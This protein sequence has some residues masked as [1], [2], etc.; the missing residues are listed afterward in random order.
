MVGGNMFLFNLYEQL[1]PRKHVSQTTGEFL[2]RYRITLTPNFSTTE[3]IKKLSFC[4][5][6]LRDA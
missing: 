5:D 6:C 4:A 3:S 2:A 1:P